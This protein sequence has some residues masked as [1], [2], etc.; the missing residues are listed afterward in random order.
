MSHQRPLHTESVRSRE[1]IA[2]YLHAVADSLAAGDDI[3]L[4]AG[5]ESVTLSPPA[6]AEFEVSVERDDRGASEEV[7]VEFEIE[8]EEGDGGEDLQVE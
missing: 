1:E 3:H 4:S 8:W 6:Q 7:E 2:D 5:E